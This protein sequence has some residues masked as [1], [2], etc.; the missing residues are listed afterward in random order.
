MNP[1]ELFAVGKIV[2]AFGIRGDVVVSPMTDSPRRFATLKRVFLGTSDKS[3]AEVSIRRAHIE[4]RGVRLKL[5]GVEDRE[6]AERIIG[7]LLCVDKPN[8]VRVPR[9]T[10]FIHD[11]LGMSVI[12]EQGALLGTVKEVLRMPA[13]DV[14]VIGH[15]AHEVMIPAVKE[16][17]VGVNL[18]E[19]RMTVH[20]IEGMR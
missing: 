8:R 4:P 18:N 19:R 5:G 20:L 13:H 17:I 9:G 1:S 6:A 10:Y 14:Y 11:I 3:A 15:E 7:W 16:F 2:K 12:D